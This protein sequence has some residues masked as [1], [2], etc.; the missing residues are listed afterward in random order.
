MDWILIIVLIIIIIVIIGII[1][2]YNGLVK[3][4][5]KVENSWSQIEVQLNRRADLIPNLVETVKGY[6]SHEKGVFE[7]VTQAR[8][9]LMNAQGAE[10][11][12]KANNILTDSLKSL[13]AVAENYPELKANENFI[14]LQDQLNETENKIAYARQFY[15]DTVMMYNNKCQTFPSNIFANAFNFQKAEFFK[16]A[17]GSNEVPKVEF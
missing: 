4:R 6:A 14:N 8:A 5:N 12:A 1:G 15:N 16:G 9:G 2:I 17:E 10:E 7:K 13:F 3:S 11:N